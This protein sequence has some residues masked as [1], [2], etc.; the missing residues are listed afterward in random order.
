MIDRLTDRA[1]R[2]LRDAPRIVVPLSE[3]ARGLGAEPG[4]LARDIADDDRFLLLEPAAPLDLTLLTPAD[5]E[6]YAAALGAAGVHSA[7]GV[8]LA[9]PHPARSRAPESPID[10]LLR[11]SVTRLL[12]L[13]PEPRLAAAAERVLTALAAAI[14]T[15]DRSDGTDPS[16]TPPPGPVDPVRDPPRRRPPSPRRP[17]YRGSR[18]G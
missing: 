12:T 6:A 1:E 17:P 4:T 5:H 15:V 9:R 14:P 18:R 13:T 10:L 2:L 7:P 16:T 3:L 11:E 8:L